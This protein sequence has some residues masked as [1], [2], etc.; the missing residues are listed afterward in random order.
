MHMKKGLGIVIALI[1]LI[2]MFVM[3][4]YNGLV[5]ADEGVKEAW[6]EV[7]NQYQRR[8]DLIDNLVNTVKGFA[9]QELEVFTEVT[10]A[11]ASA[12]QTNVDINDVESMAQFQES[13]GELSGA[14]SRL[15]VTVEAYPEL[16]SDQNFLELQSQLESTENRI[17]TARNRYNAAVKKLNILVRSFPTNII[18]NIFNFDMAAIFAAE[19][20][21]EI[22][23]EVDFGGRFD[24]EE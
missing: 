24:D 2:V 23:P 8:A 5:S 19:E 3:G 16:K 20:G 10:K 21:A 7:E 11:R 18:A 13:Q 15:L 6:G 9:D 12:S 14:L 4:R 22:A 1:I 17:A